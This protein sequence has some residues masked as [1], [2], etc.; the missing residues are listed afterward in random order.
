[1]EKPF[2]AACERNAGPILGVLKE[3]ITHEHKRLLEI[4]SGTGQH[5][6]Y[7][8]GEFPWME[9]HPSD[10]KVNHAGMIQWFKEAKLQN[11]LPPVKLDVGKDDFPKLKFDVVYTAN[12]FHIMHW[13]EC[14]S[15]MKLL[16]HRL[17]EGSLAMIYGP[18]NYNGEFTSESN[19]EFDQ[20]LKARDPL[21]GIRSFEDVN[22]NMEKNGFELLEDQEM[23]A[24]N[25]ML[26]YR[27]LK[28]VKS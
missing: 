6:V 9:W 19:R 26:V 25:R 17:R 23:P 14:K 2:S 15:F 12:T 7:F 11:I 8:A 18:F 27:R 21:S 28:F 20:T 1:M 13:K 4:G 3:H 5:A 22:N 10:L 16:G 24:N